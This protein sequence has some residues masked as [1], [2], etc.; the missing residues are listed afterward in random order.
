ML[1]WN[2]C[3]LVTRPAI[4]S[5]HAMSRLVSTASPSHDANPREQVE[6]ERAAL[7]GVELRGDDVVARDHRAE[8]EAV[9]GDAEHVGSVGGRAVVGVHEVVVPERRQGAGDRVVAREPHLVPPDLGHPP[10]GREA[11]HRARHPTEAVGVALLAVVEQHLEPDADARGTARRRAPAPRGRRRGRRRR[12]R[13]A[14]PGPPRRRG[15]RCARPWPRRRGCRPAGCGMPRCSSAY[16]TLGAFP[17][18]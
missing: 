4:T 9:V 8:L 7:L 13:P 1:S 3:A 6:A 10:V 11:P 15:A 18:R 17:A 2:C 16:W 14:W 5:K 12:A